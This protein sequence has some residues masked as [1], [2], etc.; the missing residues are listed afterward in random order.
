MCVEWCGAAEK[1]EL[2]EAKV[3]PDTYCS[4][5]FAWPSWLESPGGELASPREFAFGL[6]HVI[7]RIE[8]SR[9]QSLVPR[10]SIQWLPFLPSS[11]SRCGNK[12]FNRKTFVKQVTRLS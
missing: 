6:C 3:L 12:S 7:V 5:I 1:S 10:R 11:M 8:V 9:R 2:S 4:R